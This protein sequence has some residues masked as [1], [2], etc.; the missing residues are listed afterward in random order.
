MTHA[1]ERGLTDEDRARLF[2]LFKMPKWA[3]FVIGSSLGVVV[4]GAE[5]TQAMPRAACTPPRATRRAQPE[6]RAV[7]HR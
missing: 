6:H 1:K 2:I 3:R 5:L 7:Q 4:R